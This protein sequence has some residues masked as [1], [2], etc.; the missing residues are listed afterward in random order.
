MTDRAVIAESLITLQAVGNS[1]KPETGGICIDR[2][3]RNRLKSARVGVEVCVCVCG[4]GVVG[5]V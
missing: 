1:S 4:G 3:K 2:T 5:G